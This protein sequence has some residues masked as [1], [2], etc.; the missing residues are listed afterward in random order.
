MAQLTTGTLISA[1]FCM[2]EQRRPRLSEKTRR[3]W[4]QNGLQSLATRCTRTGAPA[5]RGTGSTRFRESAAFIRVLRARAAKTSVMGLFSRELVFASW[6]RQRECLKGR[7]IRLLCSTALR[8]RSSASEFAR[9]A[10]DVHAPAAPKCLLSHV[11]CASIG[12]EV[13]SI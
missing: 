9:G 1:H 13:S 2:R 4:S 6:L 12:E 3:L 11:V 8:L 7:A 10:R 5:L